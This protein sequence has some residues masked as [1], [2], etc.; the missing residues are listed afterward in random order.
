MKK[1]FFITLVV[2]SILLCYGFQKRQEAMKPLEHE[3]TVELVVVE[4]FV[5][6]EEGNFIDTLTREDFEIYEDGKRVDIQY[7]SVVTP[8]R[9][10]LAEEIPEDIKK[11]KI[12]LAPQKM[13]LVILFDNVNTHSFY[14]ISL[15]PQIVEMFKSLTG[16][17]EETLV[18]ELNR[19]SGMRIIQPFTSDQSLLADKISEFKVDIW[20]EFEEHFLRSQKEILEKEARLPLEARFIG[21]PEYIMWALEDEAKYLR[22]LRLG[23]SF[24]GFLAAVNY[25]RRFEGAKSVLIVSDGF[26][27]EKRG[28]G[29]VRIFDP[30]EVFGGKKIF[31]QREA[32]DEFIK[33]INEERLIFYAVSPKGLRQHFS[34]NA[35]GYMGGGIFKDEMEQWSKEMYSLQEIA[36]KTGGLYLTGQKKYEDF[37]K[38]MGR[39]LTHFY[40]ISYSPSKKRKKG[41]HKI[42]IRVKKPGLEVRY[43]KGYSDF[44]EAELEKKNLASAF[45][46]PSFFRDID[47]SCKTDFIA[48]NRGYPQFWIRLSIP[49]DQF[50][51]DQYLTYPEEMA[52]L[53]GIN[54]WS[55]NRVHTGGRMVGIK[56]GVEEGIDSLYRAFITSIVKIRPGDYE[57]RIIL[58]ESEDRIG[59]WEDT[60][61]IPDIKEYSSLT[62]FNSIFGFLKKEEKENKIPFSF[63]IGDGS[64]LLS[65]YRL[66]PFVENVFKEGNKIALF[67]QAYNPKKIKDLAFQYSLLGSENTRLNLPSEKIESH[68]DKDSKI[69]NEVYLLDFKYFPPGDYQLYIKSSDGQ[70]EQAAEIKVVS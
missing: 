57:T 2:L 32:F 11:A 40:D 60:I 6:D 14:L 56:E 31:E 61:K 69:L 19:E 7:F 49:L 30:F 65:Q 58:R 67:L 66:Y 5:T 21:N 52:L 59:G 64:L 51:K 26:H 50:R 10:L 63:S 17:V 47:F 37:I 34:V 20:K 8:E 68:F 29:S 35:P 45:L 70:V 33:L 9:E 42:E 55:E 4:V 39:D 38:E 43:K 25:I 13:K 24:S 46:S 44:T 28:I 23:D 22:R 12:P 53:F 41:Y 18:I 62:L 27:L 16:K 48:L 54:E 1:S 3:V 15:W 36:D